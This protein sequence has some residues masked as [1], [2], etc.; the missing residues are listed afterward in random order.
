MRAPVI[1]HRMKKRGGPGVVMLNLAGPATIDEVEPFLLRLFDD[2]EL[3]QL[4][5][6]SLLGRFLAKRRVPKV[7]ALYQGI[8]GGSPIVH[9]SRAQGEGMCERLDRVS[10]ETA[11]HR[12]CIAFRY[13][14]PFTD[15]ALSAMEDDGVE[16]AVAFTQYPQYS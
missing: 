10:P 9:W 13:T 2:R 4:P 3:I 7:H 14:A 8:G 11:P 15:D 12:F 5:M 6:Q 1:L 16:R